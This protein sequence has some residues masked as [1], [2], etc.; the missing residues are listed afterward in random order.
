VLIVSEYYSDEERAGYYNSYID[1]SKGNERPNLQNNKLLLESNLAQQ[2]TA[3]STSILRP[4]NALASKS[5]S[6]T[7][8]NR[9]KC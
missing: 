4:N 5:I 7:Q 9:G 2:K 6:A 8:W 3:V 1:E